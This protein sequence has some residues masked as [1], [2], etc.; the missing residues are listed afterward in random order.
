[1]RRCRAERKNQLS[2]YVVL[3][4]ILSTLLLSACSSGS[5]NPPQSTKALQAGDASRGADLFTQS[6]NGAPPCSTC[7][8]VD[9]STLVGPSFKGFGAVAGTRISGMSATDYVSQ[10]ITQ[11]SAYIVNG[12]SNLM[13]N[14]YEQHLTAQQIADLAAYVLSR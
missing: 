9:G 1:M 6:I 7:H 10:S 2:R 3:I 5:S 8:T 14:Q 12:F 4:A 11:P 13:Y